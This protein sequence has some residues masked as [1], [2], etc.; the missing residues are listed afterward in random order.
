MIELVSRGDKAIN[1]RYRPMKFSEVIG[2]E[3]TKAALAN[4]MGQGEKR[5]KAVL[6]YGNSGGGKSTISRILAMGLNCETGDSVEPCLECSS[7]KAA[8]SGEAMHISEYNMSALTG[9]DD[10]EEIVKS[11]GN[12]CFTGRNRVYILDEAQGMSTSAQN[13]LLKTLENPPKGVYCILCT[14]NPEKLLKTVKS[15]CEQFEFKNPTTN[16]IKVLLANVVKQ[17]MPEMNIEQRKEILDACLGLSYRE[18]LMKLDKFIKGGGTD[19]ISEAF[20]ANYFDFAKIV[21][22]GDYNNVLQYI[23][24]LGD[25][26]DIEASRRMLRVFFCNQIKYSLKSMELAKKY[27]LAFKILDKGFYTDPNPMPSYKVD[28]FDVCCIIKGV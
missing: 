15:R 6:L 9:K 26:F 20:Q 23:E 5:S 11:M 19:S 12:T 4:W 7:C 27:S 8:M 17:E 14:T 16:D 28:L 24:N 13:L 10:A 3:K 1:E 2:C 25:D 18:I 21:M 22:T